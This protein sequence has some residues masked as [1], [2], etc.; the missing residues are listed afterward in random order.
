MGVSGLTR[1]EYKNDI[2]RGK[3]TAIWRAG[4]MIRAVFLEDITAAYDADPALLNLLL[5]PKFK[6]L[7]S[8]YQADWRNVVTEAINVGVPAPAFSASLA[9]YDS[10][11]SPRL[12]ATL[13]QSQRVFLGETHYERMD[14]LGLVISNWMN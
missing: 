2:P 4:C 3:T 7:I 10:F 8:S 5:A 12:P 6:K 9:Y 14:L 11:R 1:N 13:L